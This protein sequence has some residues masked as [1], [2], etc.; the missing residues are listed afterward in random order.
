[1]YRAGI[2]KQS[3]VTRHRVEMGLLYRPAR[4][5]RLAEFIPGLH[6]RLKIRAQLP[7]C[8]I[9]LVTTKYTYG[10][11]RNRGSVSALTAGAYTTAFLMMVDRVKGGGRAPPPPPPGWADFT[12]ESGHC[13]SV[14]VTDI[15]RGDRGW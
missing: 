3:M 5:H 12:T 14:F 7:S 1:M 13:H 10:W 4:L 15:R 11:R 2:F 8:D 6:K 9:L